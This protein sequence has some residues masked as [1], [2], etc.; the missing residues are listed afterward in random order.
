M[1]KYCLDEWGVKG[2]AK[3]QIPIITNHNKKYISFG[4][5]MPQLVFKYNVIDDDNGATRLS[6]YQKF[7]FNLSRT[8][9][10]IDPQQENV[11]IC[12]FR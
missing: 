12:R 6:I 7:I 5:D 1:P 4:S 3:V 11:D 2:G 8:P 9:E 10:E